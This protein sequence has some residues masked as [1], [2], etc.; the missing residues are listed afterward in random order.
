METYTIR[1]A[2]ARCGVSYESMRKR[3][4]RGGVRSVKRDGVRLIPRSELER[5]G[6][7]PGS[8]PETVSSTELASLRAEL[9]QARAELAELRRLPARLDAE[10]HA[11]ELAE[12]AMHEARAAETTL[13]T[14]LAAIEA[15]HAATVQRLISGS[16]L[17]RWR[18]RRELARRSDVMTRRA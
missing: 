2:A 14:Q 10:R 13:S 16:P 7:W 6:L 5:A 11:R 12:Q 8:Q 15:Q 4:D 1:E 9:A 3:V 17:R 18:T